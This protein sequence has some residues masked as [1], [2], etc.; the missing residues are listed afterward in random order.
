MWPEVGALTGA[1]VGA[2]VMA[3]ARME[4]SFATIT[5]ERK[6]TEIVA[7]NKNLKKAF[8]IKSEDEEHKWFKIIISNIM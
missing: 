5:L 1:L 4:A 2:F 6:S 7:I 3:R 8:M